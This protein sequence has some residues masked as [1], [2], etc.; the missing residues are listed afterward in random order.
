MLVS[1]CWRTVAA[2]LPS[3]K[4]RSRLGCVT[5]VWDRGCAARDRPAG[6]APGAVWGSLISYTTRSESAR[7]FATCSLPHSLATPINPRFRY[8]LVLSAATRLHLE[9]FAPKEI[10]IGMHLVPGGQ[11]VDGTA[12]KAAGSAARSSGYDGAGFCY[13]PRREGDA[14][15]LKFKPGPYTVVLCT[16]RANTEGKFLLRVHSDEPLGALLTPIPA[17]GS[18]MHAQSFLGKFKGVATE[19]YRGQ[20]PPNSACFAFVQASSA[21]VTVR[22]RVPEQLRVDLKVSLDRPGDS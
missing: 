7:G 9:L 1:R 21:L 18:G 20:L 16:R 4:R 11:R 17:E 22:A 2:P 5:K 10:S 15:S 6:S 14:A 13:L 19:T 12:I 8:R 3:Q